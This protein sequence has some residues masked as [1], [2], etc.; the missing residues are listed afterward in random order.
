MRYLFL[1]FFCLISLFSFSQNEGYLLLNQD[2]R[3]EQLIEKQKEIHVADSTIDGF[4]IQI[5]MESGNHAVELANTAMEEFKEKYPD[6]P[7]YLVFGQP[8]YRLRVG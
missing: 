4:R 1:I 5:F 3:I 7:I 6:T 8:Y 2:Q